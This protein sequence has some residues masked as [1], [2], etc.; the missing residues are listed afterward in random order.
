M[1]DQIA[2]EAEKQIRQEREQADKLRESLAG[3]VTLLETLRTN[4]ASR[5][6]YVESRAGQMVPMF[7][8]EYK[9][10]KVSQ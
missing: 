5:Y 2:A 7:G 4:G 1:Y 9:V 3:M 10:A 8:R 6:C